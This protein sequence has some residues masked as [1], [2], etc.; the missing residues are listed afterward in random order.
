MDI[1]IISE[2]CDDFSESDNDRFLYIAKML[3]DK[4]NVEIITSNFR[5]TTKRHRDAPEHTQA[6]SLTFIKEP[7]YPGNICLRRF[8]SHFIWGRNVLAYLKKRKKPDVVYCA[9]PSLTAAGNAAR[10]CNKNDIR[11]IIDVQDLWPEAFRMVFNIPII[12]SL[13]FFPFKMMENEI[14]RRADEICAVSQTYADRAMKVNKKCENASV[15]FLGTDLEKFHENVEKCRDCNKPALPYKNKL[16]LGYCGS[17]SDSYDIKTVI[18]ALAILQSG[19]VKVPK[20]IVIGDGYKRESLEQ[21]A[22]E[23]NVDAFFTGRIPYSRVCWILSQCDMVVNPIV[24]HSAASIINKHADYAA[25]GRPVLNTQ[26]SEEYRKIIDHYCMGFNCD[27]EDPND[28]ADKIFRL[29]IHDE[30]RKTMGRNAYKCSEELFDR[31][32]SY[33]KLYASITGGV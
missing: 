23:K 32:K 8:Y 28:L 7:G 19:S 30:V 4:H 18:E 24:D 9:G 6:F 29:I 26:K 5:H 21:Y 25:C 11:F 15:V 2:F 16:W 22:K 27:N 31:K 1:V 14:Y 10:Y 17:L 12:S 13:V 20:F 3:T 33:L